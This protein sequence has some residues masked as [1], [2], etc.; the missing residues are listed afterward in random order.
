M[1]QMVLLS[2]AAVMSVLQLFE[3]FNQLKL[4]TPVGKIRWLVTPSVSLMI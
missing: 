2:P 3:F 4:F 1:N